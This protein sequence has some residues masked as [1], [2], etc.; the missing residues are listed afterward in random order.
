[1]VILVPF[2]ASTHKQRDS[3]FPA[4]EVGFWILDLDRTRLFKF[5]LVHVHVRV[6][7]YMCWSIWQICWSICTLA[8]R[9]S[10]SKHKVTRERKI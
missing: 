1:M 7:G 5:N 4:N 10:V 3:P 8:H 6:R 9:I 2:L